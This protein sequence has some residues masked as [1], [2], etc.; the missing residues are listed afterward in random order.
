MASDTTWENIKAEYITKGTSPRELAKKYKV[1]KNSVYQRAKEGN[2]EG[3]KGQFRV[4][5]GTK[6]L[7]SIQDQM[8]NDAVKLMTATD[9]LLDKVIEIIQLD[10]PKHMT[11]AGVKNI[12]ETLINLRTIKNI[13]SAEDLEEQKARIAKLK[14]EIQDDKDKTIVVT[15]EGDLNRYAQ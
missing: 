3:Q 15:L 1:S 5:T 7:D 14:K 8:V 2:W 10:N 13:K 4:E 9:A 11:P 12:S 6:I